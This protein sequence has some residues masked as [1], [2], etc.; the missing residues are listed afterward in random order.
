MERFFLLIFLLLFSIASYTKTILVLGDSLSAGYGIELEKDWVSL[1]A[2]RLKAQ[3]YIVINLSTSGDTSSNGLAK[4]PGALTRYQ[5]TIV[6][7][8][9]GANDALRG[10]PLDVLQQNLDKMIVQA[11]AHSAKVLLLATEL[12]PNYGPHYLQ[13]FRQV[14]LELVKKYPIAFHAMF[15]QKVAGVPTLMQSDGLHPN[16]QAQEMILDN[17]WLKLQPLL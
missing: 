3:D 9:L 12:P 11:R 6:I 10:L 15:L 16:Q 4:L 14:Y 17:V 7:I 5:P 2:M 1:L 13:R 8:E